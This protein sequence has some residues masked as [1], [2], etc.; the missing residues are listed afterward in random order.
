MDDIE[1]P[2]PE[3]SAPPATSATR[4]GELEMATEP[5]TRWITANPARSP[6]SQPFRDP[7][8]TAVEVL[9]GDGALAKVDVHA[10]PWIQPTGRSN[11]RRFYKAQNEEIEQLQADETL[12]LSGGLP[13][14]G[15][16]NTDAGEVST[17]SLTGGT[18]SADEEQCAVR[19]AVHGSFATN[20]SLFVLKL[21]AAVLSG[22][23]A[24]VASCA[25][26]LLDLVS[27]VVLSCTQRA[28]ERAEPYVYPQG[29][30]RLEPIGVTVFS[31]VM[32]MSS[33][34]IIAE[35]VK[36]FVAIVTSGDPGLDVGPLTY[37][38]L[39]ATIAAKGALYLY[40]SRVARRRRSVVAEA[41]AQ[42][43]RNDVVTNAVGVVAVVLAVQ[44]PDHLAVL[45]PIGAVVIAGWIIVSWVTTALDQIRKL[46][47]RAAPPGF[48]RRLTHIAFNHDER[49]VKVDTVRAYHF[50][51]RFLVEV[52]IVLPESMP[53]RETHDI[54]EALQIK[55]EALAEVERA[56]VHIDWEWEHRP[57]VDGQHRM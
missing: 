43:H 33:L 57:G 8:F 37:A 55:I 41:Y 39:G 2:T 45:D 50:G 18:S 14:P 5:P 1:A 27:G 47:G 29:K 40:C 13:T 20:V 10:L 42:D 25:D 3:T 16:R 36:R 30:A 46:A 44:F 32:A 6:R 7:N 21:V 49:I 31:A 12:L 38:I 54:G 48:V 51:E 34:Q 56:F 17:A 52:D 23:I 28:V 9:R 26:S 35:A 22:S 11:L 19:L 53:L 15:G 4:N 24:V